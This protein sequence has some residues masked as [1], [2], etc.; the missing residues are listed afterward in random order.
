VPTSHKTPIVRRLVGSL[1]AEY[2]KAISAG[3]TSPARK[4]P[5][6]RMITGGWTWS[7]QTHRA[8]TSCPAMMPHSECT[9]YTEESPGRLA[10]GR[11]RPM[12][13]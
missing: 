3:S 4:T 10:G 1:Q 7:C 11:L 5:T 12:L 8:M 2:K 9:R 13:R 6:L